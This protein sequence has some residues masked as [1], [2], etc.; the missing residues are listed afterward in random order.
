MKQQGH[1]GLVCFSLKSLE[2]SRKCK[3]ILKLMVETTTRIMMQCINMQENCNFF[4]LQ[5]SLLFH[6]IT[7]LMLLMSPAG[8]DRKRTFSIFKSLFQNLSGEKK[9]YIMLVSD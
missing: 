7:V 9:I 4:A 1:Y 6:L 8:H 3:T 5:M 2:M